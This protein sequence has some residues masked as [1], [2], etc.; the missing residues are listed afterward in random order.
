VFNADLLDL[1]HVAERTNVSLD[2]VT[3]EPKAASH[4][5]ALTA[6]KPPSCLTTFNEAIAPPN[7]LRPF[8]RTHQRFAATISQNAVDI[9]VA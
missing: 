6:L 1:T 5:V 7:P 4:P 3:F 9:D 2:G 8:P